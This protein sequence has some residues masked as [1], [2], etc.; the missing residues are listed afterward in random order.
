MSWTGRIV[1]P[2]IQIN[3]RG[4]AGVSLRFN[5]QHADFSAAGRLIGAQENDDAISYEV[6]L[7]RRCYFGPGGYG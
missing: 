6:R 4:I 2:L 7:W 3:N 1:G 5:S